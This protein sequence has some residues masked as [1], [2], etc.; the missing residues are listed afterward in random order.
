M[1]TVNPA[2][3]AE[4]YKVTVVKK[5]YVHEIAAVNLS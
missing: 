5:L 1:K 3:T 4:G 2:K